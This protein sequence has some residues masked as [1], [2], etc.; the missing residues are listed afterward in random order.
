MPKHLLQ[1]GAVAAT[2]SLLA[3]AVVILLLSSA[4]GVAAGMP[5]SVSRASLVWND[6]AWANEIGSMVSNSGPVHCINLYSV[7][8]SQS[9]MARAT[10]ADHATVPLPVCVPLNASCL[11]GL[12]QLDV[13]PL[14]NGDVSSN[15]WVE[16]KTGDLL[17]YVG[18]SDAFDANAQPIKVLSNLK[19]HGGR[20]FPAAGLAHP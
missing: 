10:Y 5:D 18:K 14:G 6:A 8:I 20:N 16:E 15:V 9:N 4:S 11:G 17:F 13:Q 19:F 7:R 2:M 12:C 3:S 1:G